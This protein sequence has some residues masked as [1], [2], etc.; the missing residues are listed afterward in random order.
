M[1][2]NVSWRAGLQL[3]SHSFISGLFIVVHLVHRD[4]LGVRLEPALLIILPE[5][6]VNTELTGPLLLLTGAGLGLS[7]GPEETPVERG[8]SA[9]GCQLLVGRA[10]GQT[11]AQ[12][13]NVGLRSDTE[14]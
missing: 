13:G 12:A 6:L 7:V 14:R 8:Q 1:A 4:A 11:G 9:G 2:G 3:Y 5:E 10:G